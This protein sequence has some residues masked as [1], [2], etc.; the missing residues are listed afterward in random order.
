MPGSRRAG[1]RCSSPTQGC[2]PVRCWSASTVRLMSA[3]KLPSSVSAAT[4]MVSSAVRG[5]VSE[6]TAR[7]TFLVK[8][9]VHSVVVLPSSTSK[10]RVFS[11]L[12]ICWNRAFSLRHCTVSSVP[13]ATLSRTASL[14][15][16]HLFG[17]GHGVSVAVGHGV[18]HRK[19][20]I[21]LQALPPAGS[22]IAGYFGGWFTVG[23]PSL[24]MY[25]VS[26][27]VKQGRVA[28]LVL[29]LSNLENDILEPLAPTTA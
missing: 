24:S 8:V 29:Y 19:G 23:K 17:D 7:V 9:A 22:Y 27:K 6:R 16:V 21:F 1:C 20:C 13:V 14:H 4:V 28:R 25:S 11:P 2:R 26:G 10:V 5:W 3:G 12:R 18:P 15:A